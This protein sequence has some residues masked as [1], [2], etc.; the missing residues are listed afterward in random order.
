MSGP[1]HPTGRASVS[2]SSPRAFGVCD[3]C[4]FTYQ[5]NSLSW[6]FNWAGSKLQNLRIAVCDRCYDKPQEQLRSLILP[7]DPE[8]KFNARPEQY[9]SEVSNFISTESGQHITSQSGDTL[10]TEIEDTPSPDPQN[11]VLYPE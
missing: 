9:S 11:P 3:R 1:W 4:G 8:P 5:L 6:Q 10:I 7:P 2:P